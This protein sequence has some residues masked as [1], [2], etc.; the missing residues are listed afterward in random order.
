MLTGNTAGT[1][2]FNNLNIDST[3][4]GV[5][6]LANAS[7]AHTLTVS[8]TANTIETE[9]GAALNLNQLTIGGSGVNFSNV[10]VD[11]NDTG[12]ALNGIV[13]SNLTGGSVNVNAAGAATGGTINATGDAVQ[14]TNVAGVS[15]NNMSID[16]SGGNGIEYTRT[17]T[18]NA[19]TR[20]T[21]V[22]STVTTG[23]AGAEAILMNIDGS[24]QANFTLSSNT[25]SSAANGNEAILVNTTGSGVKDVRF[26][27]NAGNTFTANSTDPAANFQ[28]AGSGS[29]NATV[30]N[31]VFTNGAAGGRAFVMSGN[32][33]ATSVRLNLDD[34]T[35]IDTNADPQAFQLN[36]NAGT[37]TVLNESTVNTRNT[38]GV[39]ENG[40]ITND[41]GPIPQPQ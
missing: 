12:G 7:A 16:S 38:G 29:F 41:A 8:G 6:I 13:L 9:S 31:N 24:N 37:F 34:N 21:L 35:G 33:A 27:A 20:F 22:G 2:S 36:Q 10:T 15:L 40:T 4:T 18:Q 5:G 25:V 14:I 19:T 26:L 17:T 3:G 23:A 28:L 30:T 32:G 1:T 11:L 39:E